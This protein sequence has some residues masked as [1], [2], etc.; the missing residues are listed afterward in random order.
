MTCV[1]RIGRAAAF[2]GAAA[3]G[4]STTTALAHGYAGKRFFPATITND[5]PFVADELSLPTASW[6]KNGER[7]AEGQTDVS[8]EFSKRILDNLGISFEET[9]THLDRRNEQNKSGFQNLETTLKY[10]FFT[11]A[12][13][14][15]IV[16]AGLGVEWG[17]TGAR[18]VGA[19][20]FSVL[21]PT[22]FFGKGAGDLPDDVAWLRPFAITG[23]VGYAVPTDERHTTR[24]ID[25]ATGEFE[26]EVEKHAQSVVYG[27]SLEYSLP[28]LQANV[29][30]LGWPS[31]VNRL[32]PLV[33]FSF[34]TPV[35]HAQGEDTTAFVNP[36][37]LWAGQSFQAG[38]E[39]V[40][41]LN[42]DTG[43]GVGV[44]GQLHFY[45]DD[46]FPTTIGKPIF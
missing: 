24:S 27:F 25:E 34:E 19:E 36:G 39:A 28:Y 1:I 41:P 3:S 7:P 37:V 23:L 17:D 21:T 4:F 32:I 40:V 22:V 13:H 6:F 11:D 2:L 44:I 33:E 15:A 12:E 46:L 14:E 30:D 38:V 26:R 20:S 10:Q 43:T 8:A 42:R 5:D 35:Q 9:W 29:R 16:S 45:L 18:K 31:F